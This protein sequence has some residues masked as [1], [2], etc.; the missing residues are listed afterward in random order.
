MD[1]ETLDAWIASATNKLDQCYRTDSGMFVLGKVLY[2]APEDPDGSWPGQVIRD[3]LEERRNPHIEEGF[4]FQVLNSRGVTSRG[5]DEGGKQEEEL[6]EKY[7]GIAESFADDWP[8]VARLFRE[9]SRTYKLD[10]RREEAD[11]ERHRRG[12]PR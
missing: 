5:L 10:A 3:V 9:I 6:A 7:R 2:F 8:R 12:L 1:K 11:A 4:Y